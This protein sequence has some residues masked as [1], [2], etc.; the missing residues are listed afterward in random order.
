MAKALSHE[1]GIFALVEIESAGETVMV[2][3]PMTTEIRGRTRP[4]SAKWA[5]EVYLQEKRDAKIIRVQ[6]KLSNVPI[7]YP[8]NQRVV[9]QQQP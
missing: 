1:S 6:L 7:I 2:A 8:L 4:D 3:V 9:K 5:K